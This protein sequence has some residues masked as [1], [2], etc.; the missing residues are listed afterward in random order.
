M[1][2]KALAGV[3]QAS[4]CLDPCEPR[5]RPRLYPPRGYR[6]SILLGLALLSLVLEYVAGYQLPWLS[7]RLARGGARGGPRDR[8]VGMHVYIDRFI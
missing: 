3:G 4:A 6:R 1:R 7:G 5:S 8:Q 2:S